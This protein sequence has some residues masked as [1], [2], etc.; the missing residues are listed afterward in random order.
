MLSSLF[1]Q[2]EASSIQPQVKRI[3]I[4]FVGKILL[5]NDE[6]K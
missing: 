6:P 4:N 2:T 1:L 3:Y 5:A